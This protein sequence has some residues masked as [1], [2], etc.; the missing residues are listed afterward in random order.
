MAQ[1]I[2]F[3]EKLI[4]TTI[5]PLIILLFLSIT[6]LLARRSGGKWP[7]SNAKKKS[8]RRSG[9]TVG[10]SVPGASSVESSLVTEAKEPNAAYIDFR[11]TPGRTLDLSA[12]KKESDWR[13]YARHMSVV[14]IVCYL[15]YTQVST[16]IFQTFACE[17]LTDVEERYLRA[18]FRIKC[19]SEEH[20]RYICFAAIMIFIYP[21]GI[22][23]AFAFVLW[24]QKGP[25]NPPSNEE[26]LTKEEY[27]EEKQLVKLS[28]DK[29]VA[30]TS[31]LWES[32][33]PRGYYYEVVE[34]GRRL[35]LT[36]IL[37]FILPNT[38]GQVAM[39]SIF[40]FLSLIV[41]EILKPHLDPLDR[42]LYR[43]V[44]VLLH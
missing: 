1:G 14:L 8:S 3:Y 11:G 44:R 24:K 41:F 18:D 29:N 38:S 15:I 16:V 12:E 43:T 9:G 34:C 22:P 32:Y 10:Q 19:D 42:S 4:M 31:F 20:S 26:K 30:P 13:L 2:S 23:A 36:S 28:K 25:I 39:G 33:S 27:V 40:A 21:I 6:Y 7:T 37:V 5:I 17:D 35:I